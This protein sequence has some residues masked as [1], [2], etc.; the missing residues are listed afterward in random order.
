[1]TNT[2]I[3][4]AA[5]TPIPSTT[6][7]ATTNLSRLSAPTQTHARSTSP[8]LHAL[9]SLRFFAAAMTRIHHQIMDAKAVEL[10]RIRGRI[11]ALRDKLHDDAFSSASL[12]GLLAYEKRVQEAQEWPFDQTTLVRVCASALILTVPWFG[13]A[14]AAYAVDHLSHFAG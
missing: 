6:P 10:E 4:S 11:D 2:V 5:A 3:A 12:H 14:I 13:Q 1:M 9:T 8:K 7:I